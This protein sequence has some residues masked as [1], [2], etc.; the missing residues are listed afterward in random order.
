MGYFI[1]IANNKGGIGKTTVA[2]TL[3]HAL[4]A[5]KYQKKVL[6]IDLDSQCNAT[7]TLIDSDSFEK[8]LYDLLEGDISI[9]DCIYPSKFAGLDILPN[10]ED[11]A[12]IEMELIT[13]K[14]FTV[15]KNLLAPKKDEY[16]F[17]IADCPPNLL[18]FVYSALIASD[19]VIIP[20]LASSSK[21]VKGLKTMLKVIGQVKDSFNPNLRFL[22]LLINNVDRRA[23]TPKIIIKLINQTFSETQIFKTIVPTSTQ[24][25]HAE[26]TNNTVI[27]Y[28]S[29]SPGAKAYRTLAG[30]LLEIL[31]TKDS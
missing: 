8:S 4:S 14:K 12:G 10:I 24:F 7:E 15:I 2:V 11:T 20:I 1:S 9:N 28:A 16:D 22:R 18:Y 26:I 5:R 6:L 13:Q 25:N 23:V 3:S 29:G 31:N 21:S 19:F 27:N 17:I 30:E